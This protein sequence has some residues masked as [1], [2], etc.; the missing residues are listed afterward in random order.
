[1]VGLDV[2]SLKALISLLREI[3]LNPK[4][5]LEKSGFGVKNSEL[6][7]RNAEGSGTWKNFK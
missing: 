7:A 6:R 4:W 2:M 5:L 3:Y 1:M